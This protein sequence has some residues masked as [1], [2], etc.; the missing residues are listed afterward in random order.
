MLVQ[1]H[2]AE[3]N[4]HNAL[5]HEQEKQLAARLLWNPEPPYETEVKHRI[6]TISN[7]EEPTSHDYS[8]DDLELNNSLIGDF[9]PLNMTNNESSNESENNDEHEGT[10]EGTHEGNITESNMDDAFYTQTEQL[11]D[12]QDSVTNSVSI[13]SHDSL[14]L[15]TAYYFDGL[16]DDDS[17][18]WTDC[19]HSS[20]E[21]LIEL[22]E[23]ERGIL[24][25]KPTFERS[26]SLQNMSSMRSLTA[27][28]FRPLRSQSMTPLFILCIVIMFTGSTSAT[29]SASMTTQQI[30]EPAGTCSVPWRSLCIND[31]SA[32]MTAFTGISLEKFQK[33]KSKIAHKTE[34][35]GR[36]AF[37]NFGLTS[38]KCKKKQVHDSQPFDIDHVTD[39]TAWYT[40]IKKKAG[41]STLP[42]SNFCNCGA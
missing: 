26:P 20:L 8:D 1:P 7:V 3:D 30:F 16:F 11:A 18:S 17:D 31:Y 19:G 32:H 12:M 22:D 10:H 9:V 35:E 2:N 40:Q 33:F 4:T 15:E 23:P 38:V 36:Q 14:E 28:C 21:S 24:L 39:N 13:S 41:E 25:S 37:K 6:C 27:A 34:D 42:C 5:E 29:I